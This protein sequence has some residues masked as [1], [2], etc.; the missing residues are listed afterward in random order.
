[1]ATKNGQPIFALDI[2]T[3][4]VVGIL[5]HKH[6]EGYE[7]ID[8]MAQEHTER[9]MVD[10]QIHDVMAVAQVIRTVKQKLEGKHGP[11]S[12]VA[13]AAAGRSLK[14][15]RA[16][17]SKD[18]EGRPIL[19]QEDILTM[20]LEAVQL[21]QAD[22][23]E[24]IKA[25][26][27]T[28][29][30]CVGY[31]VIR[32]TLDDE[33]IG[34]LIDQR[35]KEAAVEIIATFLPRVVVDSLISALKR[36]DLEME[37]LTL[38]PIAAINVL[39]P[40]TMRRLNI[41]LVDIGAG[42]S[43]IAL[44]SEGAITA[45]GMVPCAGDEITEAL[46][47]EY[48][49]DFNDAEQ[50]KRKLYQQE[51]VEFDDVLGFHQQLPSMEL[52]KKIQP[53]I[54]DLATQI[55]REIMNLNGKAPQAVMLIGGGA[56][57]PTLNH[58]VAD[59]LGLPENRVGIRG[60]Q[61]NQSITMAEELNLSG[62]EAV[63]PIGIAIAAEQHPVKYL[64]VTVNQNTVRLFDL[65]KL[66]IGDAILSSGININRWYGKPG[67]AISI[68]LNGRLTHIPGTLGEPPAITCNGAAASLI[69]PLQ[70]NDQILIQEG[71]T[72]R[73][74][75]AK[76]KD[77]VS[78]TEHLQ[79]YINSINYSIP[80]EIFVNQ[81]RVSLDHDVK[82]RD[83]VKIIYPSQVQDT[84]RFA[85][86]DTE[87]MKPQRI[88]YYLNQEEK[89]L[90]D[91]GAAI[92]KNKLPTSLLEPIQ[93]GDEITVKQMSKKIYTVM[94][95]IPENL[96]HSEEIVVTFNGEKVKL[97]NSRYMILLNDKPIDDSNENI[98]AG[99]QISIIEKE[100]SP[101][102]FS[103]IFRYVDVDTHSREKGKKFVLRVNQDLAAFDT[104]IR[105]GDMLELSW[106]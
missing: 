31:S 94:D 96:K 98:K 3:R 84:L 44:T 81:Q 17:V 46:S 39:I 21:A 43:D 95:V 1:M 106:E 102:C 74:A 42:T 67:L 7:V 45:Y 60:L 76:V 77:I 51:S 29:F 13:V 40:N 92:F 82:D 41:A 69:Q 85:G 73:N 28:H 35:G 37:A 90:E 93:H 104:L 32:Y 11:L 53:A 27:Q 48:I 22:L 101:L 26:D 65:R 100:E 6:A 38:E 5:L 18:I 9:S 68:E 79:V 75:V 34:N 10:G 25:L 72:G 59:L 88:H 62:P 4:S 14:T 103:D 8:Y 57:T 97:S 54:Q 83:E 56:L 99:D 70:E 78:H 61:L 15:K 19:T 71:A 105:H 58:W 12:K 16:K 86:M 23:A 24:E 47:H 20:E 49:L 64:S 55:S 52:V 87:Q 66:T 89:W 30:Y 63:T 80:P 50:I 36:A 2:G 91:P 33:A